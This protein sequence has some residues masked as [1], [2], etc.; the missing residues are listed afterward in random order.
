[1]GELRKELRDDQLYWQL[2]RVSGLLYDA[3]RAHPERWRVFWFGAAWAALCSI[4]RLKLR[5]PAMWER[6]LVW[7]QAVGEEL[8]ITLSS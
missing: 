2:K 4:H 3:M 1:M 6:A 7:E 5:D 8:G